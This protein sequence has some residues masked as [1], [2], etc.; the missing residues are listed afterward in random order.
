MSLMKKRMIWM[1][2][3]VG[4]LFGGLLGYQ[5]FSA[6]MMKAQLASNMRPPATVTAMPATYQDWQP[7]LHAIGSLRAVHGVDISTEVAGQVSH[8]YVHSG[9]MVRR[10]DLLVELNHTDEDARLRAL[11]ADARL[12]EISYRRDKAQ[13]AARAISQARFDASAATYQ[14]SRAAV[15]EQRALIAKKRITAPFAGRLGI[16][17]LNPGQYLNPADTVT[18]LQDTTA[19]FVDFHLPQ[20]DINGIAVGQRIRVRSDAWPGRGFAGVITAISAAVDP[21]TRNVRIEGRIENSDGLLYPGMF[22]SLVVEHGEKQRYL[23]LPQTALAYNAYGVTVFIAVKAA[24]EK[25]RGALPVAR[26][27]FVKT[28]PRRGDQ[29]AILSGIKAGDMIVTSGQM[30]LKNGTPL[31]IDNHVRPANDPAPTPRER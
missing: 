25:G 22:V 30:K 11:Q 18:T 28:G 16:V 10:G 21:A 6:H 17:A 5:A 12:A 13:L 19:L 9:Q 31:V 23:T 4:L 1:F 20:K 24:A 15:S 26:Q 14:H 27:V 7:S 3:G 8:V 29:V 2:L